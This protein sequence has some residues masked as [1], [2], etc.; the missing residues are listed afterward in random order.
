MNYHQLIEQFKKNQLEEEVRKEVA[1]EIEKQEAISEYLMEQEE[2]LPSL[3]YSS[4]KEDDDPYPPDAEA[5]RMQALTQASGE[6]IQTEFTR[7]IR[8]SIRKAFWKLGAAAGLFTAAVILFILFALPKLVAS[9]YYNPAQETAENTK[10]LSLDLAVYTELTTPGYYRSNVSVRDQGYGNYG[11]EIFQE[12]SLNGRM[13]H[14]SGEI[15]KGVFT[16]YNPNLLQRPSGNVFAWFQMEGGSSD[17]LTALETENKEFFSAAGSKKHADEALKLLDDQETYIAYVTLDQMMPYEA[18][19]QYLNQTSEL[20]DAWC[21]VST[22]DNSGISGSRFR[23]ENLG[24]RCQM[25]SSTILEWDR[26]AYPNLLLWD[27]QTIQKGQEKELETNMQKEAFMRTH[28]TSL[29]RYMSHQEKFLAMMGETPETYANAADYVE[30]NGLMIYGF[31]CV[32]SKKAI[33]R[34]NEDPEVYQIYTQ[35]LQ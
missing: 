1:R 32:G 3:D 4:R 25:I 17:S 30:K 14:L 11:V 20:G 5:T 12:Y 27:A 28:F 16:R 22:E 6:E 18:F 29:L 33:C 9:F 15:Q 31:A 7:M 13:T 35:K 21:A 10:Q 26:S 34:L 24:F 2:I 19:I 23:T 8:R